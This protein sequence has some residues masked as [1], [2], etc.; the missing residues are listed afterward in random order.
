MTEPKSNSQLSLTA[1]A[2]I[3]AEACESAGNAIA[4]VHDRVMAECEKFSGQAGNT[5]LKILALE[6]ELQSVRKA[7]EQETAAHVA[8]MKEILQ[9]VT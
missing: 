7:H 5:T 6:A 3:M 4:N 2:K 1:A 8:R 9:S